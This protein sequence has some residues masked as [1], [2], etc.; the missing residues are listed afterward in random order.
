MK[1]VV[2]LLL[3]MV[4]CLAF[5]APV[6]AADTQYKTGEY[7]VYSGHTDFGYYYTYSTDNANYKCFSVVENGQTCI[8]SR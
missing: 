3:T 5:A 2:S 1:K 8:C 7:V 6:F 4:L